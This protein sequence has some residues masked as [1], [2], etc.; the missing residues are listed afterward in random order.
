MVTE[1]LEGHRDSWTAADA[2]LNPVWALRPRADKERPDICGV[3]P[4]ARS[5]IAFC[6]RMNSQCVWGS[7]WLLASVAVKRKAHYHF[8]PRIWD[9]IQQY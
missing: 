6:D 2:K 5:T 9:Q 1:W 4:H 3:D 8:W 7:V